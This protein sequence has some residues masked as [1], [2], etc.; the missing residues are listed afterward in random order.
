MAAHTKLVKTTGTTEDLKKSAAQKT[1]KNTG[2]TDERSREE[3]ARLSAGTN[4]GSQH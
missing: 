2:E 1:D 3:E 4:Y